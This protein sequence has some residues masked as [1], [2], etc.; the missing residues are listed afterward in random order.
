MKYLKPAIHL[1]F[2]LTFVYAG[3]Y[4]FF[5]FL[6]VPAFIESVQQRVMLAFSD[7]PWLMPLLAAVELIGGLL[8]LVPR[9]R[10]FA[11]VMLLPVIVGIVLHNITVD[12]RSL[13]IAIGVGA[14]E[15]WVLVRHHDQYKHVFDLKPA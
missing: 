13:F 8:F 2:G 6:P 12:P 10:A 5:P 14:V 3:L 9:T 11:A 4:K 7:M 1:G 15:C